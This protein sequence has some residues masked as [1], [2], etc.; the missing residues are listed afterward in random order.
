MVLV[1]NKVL[2]RRQPLACQF[3]KCCPLKGGKLRQQGRQGVKDTVPLFFQTA[4]EVNSRGE[5][6]SSH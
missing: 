3:W 4:V 2:G 5:M 6:P 1:H